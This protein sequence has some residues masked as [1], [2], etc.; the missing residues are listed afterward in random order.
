MTFKLSPLARRQ[1]EDIWLYTERNWGEAQADTYVNGLFDLLESLPKKKHLWRAVPHDALH[2]AL[3]ASYREHVI[4]FRQFPSLTLGVIAV[5]HQ[6]RD[7]P[8]RLK[9]L[10]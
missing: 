5:L 9:E 2:G 6:S 3:C 1:I 8:N 4:F 10:L 7:I